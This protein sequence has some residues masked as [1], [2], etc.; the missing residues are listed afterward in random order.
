MRGVRRAGVTSRARAC[1]FD[2][3]TTTTTTRVRWRTGRSATRDRCI[4]FLGHTIRTK[5]CF[6]SVYAYMTS[7]GHTIRTKV[8]FVSVYAYMTSIGHTIRTKVFFFPVYVYLKTPGCGIDRS[9]T[10]GATVDMRSIEVRDAIVF[11]D[12]IRDAGFRVRARAGE[13]ARG[14]REGGE[15]GETRDDDAD[16]ARAVDARVRRD[17][18]RPH[19]MRERDRRRTGENGRFTCGFSAYARES[20]ASSEGK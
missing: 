19:R 5:V 14:D 17:V 13:R 12:D 1:R 20:E 7:I 15:S 8:C 9:T 3:R 11:R 2:G 4:V 18:G 6:V 10:H 16:D